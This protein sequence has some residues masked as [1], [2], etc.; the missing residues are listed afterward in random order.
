MANVNEEIL[1]FLEMDIVGEDNSVSFSDEAK[2]LIHDI[3]LRC[4]KAKIVRENDE[5]LCNYK[6]NLSAEDVYV[7]MLNKIIIAPTS[8]HM[9]ATARMLIPI[10]DE[11][12]RS[13]ETGFRNKEKKKGEGRK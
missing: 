4:S 13:G 3:T 2:R 6:K 1:R 5:R 12:I 9:I 10:I 7:D 11:K 8:F